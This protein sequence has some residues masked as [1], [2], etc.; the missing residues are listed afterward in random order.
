MKCI[1]WG[2]AQN[3]WAP[4]FG[5]YWKINMA[6]NSI[7]KNLAHRIWKFRELAWHQNAAKG[8]SICWTQTPRNVKLIFEVEQMSIPQQR[9]R[10]AFRK[11]FNYSSFC[12][13]FLLRRQTFSFLLS[14]IF[15][16]ERLNGCWNSTVNRQFPPTTE[17]S[18]CSESE[19]L[20][21]RRTEWAS[22]LVEM[23]ICGVLLC[24]LWGSFWVKWNL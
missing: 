19:M 8:D 22:K 18:W 15:H 14:Y 20:T 1:W 3:D 12:H 21:L 23:R 11:A 4:F 10:K 13:F 7:N 9:I 16:F 2:M 17:P 6:L 5:I 24:G